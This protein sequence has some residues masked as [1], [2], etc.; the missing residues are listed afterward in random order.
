MVLRVSRSCMGAQNWPPHPHFAAVGLKHRKSS[1]APVRLPL[2]PSVQHPTGARQQHNHP[3]SV[4]KQRKQLSPG[5]SLTRTGDFLSNKVC[6]GGEV[7]FENCAQFR[8]EVWQ[9]VFLLLSCY[10]HSS[11]HICAQHHLA[12][13]HLGFLFKNTALNM[14]KSLLKKQK[15][16]RRTAS[17]C[18]LG[19]RSL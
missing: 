2:P 9:Q 4:H 16:C 5:N 6:V 13:R 11:P 19:E 18:K 10:R 1:R 7:L 8:P 17:A 12:F 3:S 15:P 14:F